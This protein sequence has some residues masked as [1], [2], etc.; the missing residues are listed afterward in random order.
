M[1]KLLEQVFEEAKRLPPEKQ[2]E[3]ARAIINIM[4]GRS[5]DDVYVLSEAE[6]AAIEVA[7]RQVARGEFASEEE[8]EALFKTY[9][10]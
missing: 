6:R 9:A 2:D 4:S 5:D 7:R 3:L 1:T 8:I 10:S